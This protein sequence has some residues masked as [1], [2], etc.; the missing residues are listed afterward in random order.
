V[1]GFA[2][3]ETLESDVTIRSSLSAFDRAP[4]DLEPATGP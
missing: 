4:A 2:L 1:R 3:Q